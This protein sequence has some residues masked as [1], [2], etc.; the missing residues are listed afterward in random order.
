MQCV[1]IV[2]SNT[3]AFNNE[4]APVY[5]QSERIIVIEDF[6]FDWTYFSGGC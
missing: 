1:D 2:A 5:H 3:C 4:I 6:Y